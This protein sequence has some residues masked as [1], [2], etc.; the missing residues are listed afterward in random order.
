MDAETFRQEDT[1]FEEIPEA[2]LEGPPPTAHF[3]IVM[4]S[5]AVLNDFVINPILFGVSLVVPPLGWGLNLFVSIIF[6][7]ALF[8]W[9]LG[10]VSFVQKRLVRRLVNKIVVTPLVKVIPGLSLLIPQSVILVLLAHNE[11]KKIVK[12]FLDNL[13]KLKGFV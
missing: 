3:P 4:F 13:E 10:K 7:L 6:S 8:F 5:F 2:E 11:E 9:L 12:L 1:P